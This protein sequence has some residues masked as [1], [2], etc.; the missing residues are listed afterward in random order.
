MTDGWGSENK[1]CLHPTPFLW[2]SGSGS[3]FSRCWLWAPKNY[4]WP[5]YSLPAFPSSAGYLV[6]FSW[7]SWHHA[8]EIGLLELLVLEGNRK[9]VSSSHPVMIVQKIEKDATLEVKE[10]APQAS[11]IFSMAWQRRLRW[12]PAS[13]GPCEVDLP[14]THQAA[15][16]CSLCLSLEKQAHVSF[17]ISF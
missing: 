11:L 14:K 4:C 3:A 12:L 8:L 17:K 13:G 7:E 15:P 16:A 6:S 5:K 10:N 9:L 1:A 2:L